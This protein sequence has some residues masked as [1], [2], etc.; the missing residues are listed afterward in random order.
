M[1][2]ILLPTKP[3]ILA[4][5]L[6]LVVGIASVRS[7]DAPAAK[8]VIQV[9]VYGDLANDKTAD[10]T[11][12]VVGMVKDNSL[13]I[14]VSTAN[15]G[16]PAPGAVKQLRVGYTVDGVYH[17]KTVDEDDTLDISTRLVV[18]K[19]VYGDLPKGQFADVTEDV[20][21]LV[22]RNALSVKADNDIFGDP[23]EGIVKKLRVDYTFDGKQKSKTV[24]DNETL[25]ISDKGE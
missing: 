9:A 13:W 7:A 20:A 16:D 24:N 12:K 22:Q 11:Q 23:A 10:V 4:A 8:L 14:R 5:A 6:C 2:R 3:S 19:A 1:P 21:A 25:T 15:I 18:R 17:S